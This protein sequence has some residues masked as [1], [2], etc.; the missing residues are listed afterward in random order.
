MMKTPFSDRVMSDQFLATENPEMLTTLNYRGLGSLLTRFQESMTR[1]FLSTS[2]DNWTRFLPSQA[3]MM[4]NQNSRGVASLRRLQAC[5][6]LKISSIGPEM[7]DL[8]PAMGN[9]KI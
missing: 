3:A 6:I 9:P 7:W 5:Q 4:S 1:T 8:F 2:R